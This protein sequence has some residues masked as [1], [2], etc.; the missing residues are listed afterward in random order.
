LN[1]SVTPLLR[2]LGGLMCVPEKTLSKLYTTDLVR[3]RGRLC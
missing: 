3:R 2:C 1:L